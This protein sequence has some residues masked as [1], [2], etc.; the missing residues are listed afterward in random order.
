MLSRTSDKRVVKKTVTPSAMPSVGNVS[1]IGKANIDI[2]NVTVNGQTISLDANAIGYV[3]AVTPGT[4]QANKAVVVDSNKSISGLEDISVNQLYV[5][6]EIVTGI[7]NTGATV[8]NSVYLNDIQP[9]VSRPNK[10]VSTD[11][12]KNTNANLTASSIIAN[13]GT[14]QAET[15]NCSTGTNYM[16]QNLDFYDRKNIQVSTSFA[17]MTDTQTLKVEKYFKIGKVYVVTAL[18]TATYTTSVK[19]MRDIHSSTPGQYFTANSCALVQHYYCSYNATTGV[20]II[21]ILVYTSGQYQL[22]VYTSPAGDPSTWSTAWTTTTVSTCTAAGQYVGS[23][24]PPA[25][26]W[27]TLLNKYV[28][29]GHSTLNTDTYKTSFTRLF[30][31]TDGITWSVIST[32]PQTAVPIAQLIVTDSYLFLFDTTTTYYWSSNGTTWNSKT[33]AATVL[34]GGLAVCMVYYPE[35]DIVFSFN[36]GNRKASTIFSLAAGA[37]WNQSDISY[38]MIIAAEALPIYQNGLLTCDSTILGTQSFIWD[39]ATNAL[40]NVPGPVMDGLVYFISYRS[41]TFASSWC[42]RYTINL[43]KTEKHVVMPPETFLTFEHKSRGIIKHFDWSEPLQQYVVIGNMDDGFNTANATTLNVY[44]SRDLENFTYVNVFPVTTVTHVCV[45]QQNGAIYFYK[46]NGIMTNTYVSVDNCKTF[47]NPYVST[48]PCQGIYYV[49]CLGTVVTNSYNYFLVSVG[50]PASYMSTTHT[51]EMNYGNSLS[52]VSFDPFTLN[53]TF[54]GSSTTGAQGNLMGVVAGASATGA[55]R[56]GMLESFGVQGYAITASYAPL[57]PAPCTLNKNAVSISSSS[58]FASSY[59]SGN[60]YPV[61]TWVD[62]LGIYVTV[63]PNT[64]YTTANRLIYSYDGRVWIEPALN[65]AA[66]NTWSGA[67]SVFDSVKYDRRTGRLYLLGTNGFYQTIHSTKGL[68][69]DQIKSVDLMTAGS[70]ELWPISQVANVQVNDLVYCRGQYIA[71]Y[72]GGLYTGQRVGLMTQITR[73]GNWKCAAASPSTIVI[74]SSGSVLYGAT[75]GSLSSVS[76]SGD[77]QSVNWSNEVQKFGACC[78]GTLAWSSNGSTW[79][80]LSL[81]GSWTSIKYSNGVWIATGLNKIAISSDSS[82]ASTVSITGDWRDSAFG[83][84]WLLVGQG[85]VAFNT[86][87]NDTTTW[88]VTPA[89][90]YTSVHYNDNIRQFLLTGSDYS[91]YDQRSNTFMAQTANAS[92]RSVWL[93]TMQAY[94]LLG[95]TIMTTNIL[96]YT[97]D[98][99]IC[100]NE[101][102]RAKIGT[103]STSALS[104]SIGSS[105]PLTNGSICTRVTTSDVVS[106]LSLKNNS[107]G[108]EMLI[109]SLGTSGISMESARG[110]NLATSSIKINSLTIPGLSDFSFTTAGASTSGYLSLDGSNNFSYPSLTVDCLVINGIVCSSLTVPDTTAGTLEANKSAKLDSNKSLTNVN[111][112]ESFLSFDVLL[113]NASRPSSFAKYSNGQATTD[114]SSNTAKDMCYHPNLKLYAAVSNDI[115]TNTATNLERLYI[116][117]SKDGINWNK[118]YTGVTGYANRIIPV[119]SGTGMYN[120]LG[121]DSD[122]FMICLEATA[123]TYKV[124]VSYDLVS[125]Y[126]LNAN[127]LLTLTSFESFYGANSTVYTGEWSTSTNCSLIVHKAQA[128]PDKIGEFSSTLV[129]AITLVSNGCAS[130]SIVHAIRIPSSTSNMTYV[131]TAGFGYGNVNS[132]M[133]VVTATGYTITSADMAYNFNGTA[134]NFMRVATVSGGILYGTTTT[135]TSMTQ[136]TFLTVAAGVNFKSV[137]WNSFIRRFLIVGDAGNIYISGVGSVT[138]WTKV[139]IPNGFVGV[140]WNLARHAADQGF[141]VTHDNNGMAVTGSKICRVTQDGTFIQMNGSY[142]RALAQGAYLPASGGQSGVYVVPITYSAYNENKILYSYDG[143]A[144]TPTCPMADGVSKIIA[145]PSLNKLF[146]ITSA[147]SILMSTDGISWSVVYTHSNVAMTSNEIIFGE[148]LVVLFNGALVD[149]VVTSVDGT[150]WAAVSMGTAAVK[151]VGYLPTISRYYLSYDDT[152][153]SGFYTDNFVSSTAVSVGGRNINYFPSLGK[154]QMY[155]TQNSTCYSS[156]DCAT[157]TTTTMTNN[158]TNASVAAAYY[159]GRT[160]LTVPSVG[161]VTVYAID[162][163]GAC[164]WGLANNVVTMLGAFEGGMKADNYNFLIYNS[165]QNMIMTYKSTS[166]SRPGEAFQLMDLNE[167]AVKKNREI[168]IDYLDKCYSDQPLIGDYQLVQKANSTLDGGNADLTVLSASRGTW[169]S[170]TTPSFNCM[171]WSPTVGLFVGLGGS[172][173]STSPDGKTWTARTSVSNNG[174]QAVKWIPFINKYVAVAGGGSNRAAWSSDGISWTPVAIGAILDAGDWRSIATNGTII[175]AVAGLTGTKRVMTSTDGMAWTAG[176]SADETAAW[177]SVAWSSDLGLFVAVASSGTTRAMV[178]SDGINWTLRPTGYDTLSWLGVEWI[179]NI[180]AFVAVGTSTATAMIMSYNGYDWFANTSF[181]GYA[182]YG[183]MW[184]TTLNRICVWSINAA[185]RIYTSPN[186][187]N[188][189]YA[190]GAG[191]TISPTCMSDAR[192]INTVLAGVA[193]ATWYVNDYQSQIAYSRNVNQASNVFINS[194]VYSTTFNKWYAVDN[195]TGQNKPSGIY[196]STDGF[197]WEYTNAPN[198]AYPKIIQATISGVPTLVALSGS[199]PVSTMNV[200]LSTDGINW[201]SYSI[202]DSTTTSWAGIEWS[203]SLSLFVAITSS[204][205]KRVY[206]SPDG[207]VWTA[208]NSADDTKAW[209][210]LVWASG[211]GGTGRFIAT[212]LNIANNFMYSSDGINWSPSSFSDTTVAPYGMAY[213]SSLGLVVAVC[214]TGTYRILTS[215]D[216][217]TWTVRVTSTQYIAAFYNVSW[218]GTYFVAQCSS[219]IGAY[220]V[221]YDGINWFSKHIPI[222]AST[223]AISGAVRN[224]RMVRYVSNSFPT[225]IDNYLNFP[226]LVA[227]TNVIQNMVYANGTLVA[228]T[229]TTSFKTMRSTNFHT[230]TNVASYQPTYTWI[231]AATNGT[232]IYA[233]ATNGTIMG[234]TDQGAT[235]SL[236]GGLT[237][238]NLRNGCYGDSGYIF[239]G[240]TST[241]RLVTSST[242]SS[243]SASTLLDSK[244]MLGCCFGGPV[245]SKKYIVVGGPGAGSVCYSPNFTGWNFANSAD[246]L[247][248][249]MNVTWSDALQLF[250]AVG[251][252]GTSNVNIMTSPDGINWTARTSPLGTANMYGVAAGSNC[253]VAVGM[254]SGVFFVSSDGINWSLLNTENTTDSAYNVTYI[255][256]IDTFAIGVFSGNNTVHYYHHITADTTSAISNY[257]DSSSTLTCATWTGSKFVG[258][259]I[260]NPACFMVSHD[261]KNWSRN[262]LASSTA[263]VFYGIAYGTPSAVPGGIYVAVSNT[264]TKRISYSYDT[265]KWT[266]IAAPDDTAQW[267]SIKYAKGIFTTVRS[268]VSMYS[269]NGTTWALGTATTATGNYFGIEYSPSLD[270]FVAVAPAGTNQIATSTDGIAWTG[271]TA[272]NTNA[273]YGIAWSPTLAMFVAVANSGTNKAMYSYNGINWNLSTSS[274]ETASWGRVIWASGPGVFIATNQAASTSSNIM[275]SKDGI[276]WVSRRYPNGTSQTLDYGLAYSPELDITIFANN[277]GTRGHWFKTEQPYSLT[278]PYDIK[279]DI[280]YVKQ[281]GQFI[282]MKKNAVTAASLSLYSSTDGYSWATFASPSASVSEVTAFADLPVDD[283]FVMAKGA[284]A[285]QAWFPGAAAAETSVASVGNVRSLLFS[286]YLGALIIGGSNGSYS[287]YRVN[288]TAWTFALINTVALPTAI[289]IEKIV[290][291]NGI[292]LFIGPTSYYWTKDFTVYTLGSLPTGT[293]YFCTDSLETRLVAVNETGTIMYTDDAVNWS[294]V[295]TG[296]RK[297]GNVCYIEEFNAFIACDMLASSS[298]LVSV[299]KGLT[300]QTV[301]LPSS[302]KVSSI[303]YNPYIDSFVIA[304]IGSGLMTTVVSLPKIAAPGNVLRYQNPVSVTTGVSSNGGKIFNIN[305]KGG[306]TFGS[307]Q[308]STYDTWTTENV[309]LLSLQYDSAYKPSSGSWTVTSDMRLKS[310]ITRLEPQTATEILKNIELYYYK[311]ASEVDAEDEHKLGWIAQEVEKEVPSAVK[312][313]SAYGYDDFKALSSDQLIVVMHGCLQD[314]IKRY[315][316]LKKKLNE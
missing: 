277:T 107:D 224:N 24:H 171:A 148:R 167:S 85:C 163:A 244:T 307:L 220:F 298:L 35:L 306:I 270:L 31:S 205:T 2:S 274:D 253:V 47:T 64:G 84:Q 240:S 140:T 218:E 304:T 40:F 234:S 41:A 83:G 145:V 43:N 267:S 32:S 36:Q 255:P 264:G 12:N 257:D 3:D 146:T 39:P 136:V 251:I 6:N 74:M 125:F 192:S 54:T 268:A 299:D 261:G 187:F 199:N 112:L 120:S 181:V 166:G 25:V 211:A 196:T 59:V 30:G 155:N 190:L 161:E 150:V 58:S 175:V 164:L 113:A 217:N 52:N 243:W 60:T 70:S 292:H 15:I 90:M 11:S 186:A 226:S 10:I 50:N 38:N 219:A 198:L 8:S 233:S 312:T 295:V 245:G 154:L 44:F 291:I 116:M 139:T 189:H 66:F 99:T 61:A 247:T 143:I 101:L 184:S 98:N 297:W 153:Y 69:L 173:L 122:C 158:L 259:C 200:H 86:N 62:S 152:L 250:I 305:S 157:W 87:V 202:G 290:Y 22:L 262:T 95:S 75:A 144:W 37:T 67:A 72:N 130:T 204:G 79:T 56:F 109:K 29:M 63:L 128:A 121:M 229:T 168:P 207:K 278:L 241:N 228:I 4:A 300:W 68:K 117:V 142:D 280:K 103:G 96:G 221:S 91:V 159:F 141:L 89:G 266:Q 115:G 203:S 239:V 194:S 73:A 230:W 284:A 176:S 235:W 156:S 276:N 210:K 118:C 93:P 197:L 285:F 273:W 28:M 256:S 212:A 281:L 313:I 149:N 248:T 254:T 151:S 53:L 215:P 216:G 51:I 316:D 123:S 48:G 33:L 275:I 34:T 263:N 287:L 131:D 172:I 16:M 185:Y 57:A 223:V 303:A 100:S 165:D 97:L 160:Y 193:S 246:A 169:Y 289:S 106:M 94:Y 232:N 77:W 272:P 174:W 18:N 191:T 55:N 201:R 17:Y 78:D 242:G 81:A 208:R 23:L 45:N 65:A 14:V 108:S 288:K 238:S 282:A 46:E 76:L 104:S 133:N 310:D 138:T 293:W 195:S 222:L 180:K 13:G 271:R 111:Q 183:I 5:N 294:T 311:W 126:N 301:G 209:Y 137:V 26:R 214:P 283:G 206:T 1:M 124:L 258:A 178:S 179:P 279:W 225:M 147:R 249:W 231:G 71:C 182:L 129:H 177:G 269:T 236:S 19:V 314:L 308:V 302:V 92:A 114:C 315:S 105:L 88:N 82:T 119:Y 27:S 213:S 188:W 49:E 127:A 42:W 7:V 9:G 110:F 102:Y 132:A 170:T 237:T 296:S 286:R 252:P 21:P 135:V 260:S 265:L 20:H 309:P 227:N 134:N 80:T 162:P